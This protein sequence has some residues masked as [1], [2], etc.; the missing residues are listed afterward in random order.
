MGLHDT[1]DFDEA[2]YRIKCAERPTPKLQVEEVK[3]LRQHFAASAS[4]AIGLSHA[5][6]TAGLTLGV[7][8]LGLRR[9]F[10]A[11]EKLTIIR[12]ELTKRGVPLHDMIGGA[13][14]APDV[15]VPIPGQHGGGSAMHFIEANPEAAG[16]GFAQG[17]TDQANAVGHAVHGAI[18]G[19]GAEQVI[20]AGA[21]EGASGH[22]VGYAAGIMAAKKMEEF[23]GECAGE[24][25]FAYAMEK[26]L[27]PEIKLELQLKGKCTRLQGPLGQYCRGCGDSI[28]HG[29]FAH[30]CEDTDDFDLCIKCHEAGKSCACSDNRMSIMQK[31]VAGDVLASEKGDARRRLATVSEIQCTECQRLITQGRYYSGMN[32]T[33]I[34]AKIVTAKGRHV[35]CLKA[36]DFTCT[37]GPTSIGH[38]RMS[39]RT[40]SSVRL[41]E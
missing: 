34:Y 32:K 35:G 5:V 12:E 23:L 27:D 21:I 33:S 28:R 38:T 19:H 20:H 9:Y 29:K 41:A 6:Q 10:V 40:S 4:M 36:I 17:I 26:L 25:I 31:S 11:K 37:S 30:C 2:A 14:A 1:F 7:S 18:L 24:T 22:T 15:P 39:L 8:A 3:K 16:H 13:I